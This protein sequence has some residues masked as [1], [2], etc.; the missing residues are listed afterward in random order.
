MPNGQ[1]KKKWV[2]IVCALLYL[3]SGLC[4]VL[5]LLGVLLL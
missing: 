1:K 3:I 4:A 2:G 5:M